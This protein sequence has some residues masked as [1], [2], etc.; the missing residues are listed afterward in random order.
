MFGFGIVVGY[1]KDGKCLVNLIIGM[2]YSYNNFML[3]KFCVFFEF[4]IVL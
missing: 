1:F 2:L 4:F 3:Y